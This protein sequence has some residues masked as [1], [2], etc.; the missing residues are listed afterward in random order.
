[1]A[2]YVSGYMLKPNANGGAT[3]KDIPGADLDEPLQDHTVLS[4][5]CWLPILNSSKPVFP[6][7][8]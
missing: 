4:L 5:Q 3:K 1:M 8:C 6:Q 7:N 2:K